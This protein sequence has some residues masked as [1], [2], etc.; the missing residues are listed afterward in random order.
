MAFIYKMGEELEQN[1]SACDGKWLLAPHTTMQAG[2]ASN[3][4]FLISSKEMFVA[5]DVMYE[6]Y[7]ILMCGE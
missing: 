5:F 7:L 3:A 2:D 4:N 6:I 1:C